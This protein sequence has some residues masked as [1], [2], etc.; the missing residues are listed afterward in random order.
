MGPARVL[1]AA[2]AILG[3]GKQDGGAATSAPPREAAV[4]VA[5]APGRFTRE[6][7]HANERAEIALRVGDR[8]VPG[9]LVTPDGTGP[10]PAVLL[11]AGSGPT[12]RNWENPII[13]ATN[14]SARL[15]AE[16]LSHRGAVTL[17]FDKAGSGKNPPPADMTFDTYLDEGRA[18]LAYL[19]GLPGVDP[20]R[21]FV[22][23]HS[24]GGIH[25]IRL[26]LADPGHVAGLIF[27]SSAGR[28]M[29]DIIVGQ[30]EDQFHDAGFTPDGVQANVEPVRQAFADFVAGV[31]VDVSKV[32]M[33]PAVRQL[34]AQIVDPAG[35]AVARGLVDY[36]PAA[37]I[38]ALGVPVFIFNGGKDVQVDPVRDAGRLADAARAAKL[39]V[40]VHLSPD[41]DHVLKH[42]PQ[43]MEQLR[44][45]RL[46]V[47]NAYNADGRTLDDDF[48]MALVGWLIAR[49]GP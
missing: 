39:V 33:V 8:D 14:G 25:A 22:A 44:A 30:L 12:D 18:A 10:F 49:T 6:V 3:C 37:H 17:R 45:N 9:T 19:R 43:T 35:A 46:A 38:G 21:V 31:P 36:D 40:T 20:A 1:I 23:G 7:A 16:A 28:R 41:A 27:L 15:L 4:V 47:Q 2:A 5:P 24:E 32:S 29:A 26:A 48:L 13:P 42:E 34:V 11:L